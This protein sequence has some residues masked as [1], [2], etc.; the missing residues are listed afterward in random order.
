M[1]VRE[2]ETEHLTNDLLHVSK[3]QSIYSH[4]E[5]FIPLKASQPLYPMWPC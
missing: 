3:Q 2:K 1:R 5:M 4:W